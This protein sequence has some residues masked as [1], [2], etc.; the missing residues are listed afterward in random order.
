MVKAF[1]KRIYELVFII[2]C[3]GHICISTGFNA[4]YRTFGDVKIFKHIRNKVQAVYRLEGSAGNYMSVRARTSTTLK[5]KT[6]NTT[7]KLQTASPR[8][9]ILLRPQK[10]PKTIQTISK[11]I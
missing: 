6:R 8:T 5:P 4:H 1:I 7:V 9:N 11:P 10:V 3:I 2:S